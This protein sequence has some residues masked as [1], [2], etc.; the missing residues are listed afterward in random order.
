MYATKAEAKRELEANK[1]IT[2]YFDGNLKMKDT[3]SAVG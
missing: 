3:S 2:A 1:N